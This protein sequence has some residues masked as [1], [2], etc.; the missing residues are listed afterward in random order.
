VVA[1]VTRLWC[2]PATPDGGSCAVMGCSI[3][4]TAFQDSEGNPLNV[5]AAGL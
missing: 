4:K 3:V 1:R 2:E 5:Q